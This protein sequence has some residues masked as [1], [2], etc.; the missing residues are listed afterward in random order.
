MQCEINNQGFFIP[1]SLLTTELISKI[2]ADL[3]VSPYSEFNEYNVKTFKVYKV[4][5]DSGIVIP[6][7]YA[8]E[9]L[10]LKY[11]IN[12]SKVKNEFTDNYNTNNI[13]LRPGTQQECF[14]IALGELNKPFGGGILNLTTG[15]GKSV[16]SLK[17]IC[18]SK[19]KALII[20]N[21]I[22]LMNQWKTEIKKFIPDATIGTIQGKNFD[23]EDKDIVIGM[24]QTITIKNEVT[25][26]NFFFCNLVILDEIHNFSSEVFS[27]IIFKIRPKF[28]FGLTATLQRKDKLEKLLHWYVGPVLYSNISNEKKDETEIHIY[29]YKGPSSISVTLRDNK[30]PAC[31]TM[32]TN[33]AEDTERSQ[34]IISILQDLTINKERNV[35][36]IS[37]RISQLEYMNKHLPNSALFIGTMKSE[38]L[39]KSKESQILLATYKLA[40]EGFSLAKLNCLLF[41]TSRT[42]INQAIGRI[43]RKKHEIT[44]IIVDIYDDFSFFKSQYYK[45]RKTYK[46]LISNCIFKNFTS[47]GKKAAV[48]IDLP[49]N[50]TLDFED[51]SD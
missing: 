26:H 1:K 47:K 2:K 27:K 16:L 10:D 41:A 40:S 20:V 32:L 14:N 44:P 8:L 43:Y 25:F 30:T 21:T 17:L 34:L 33:I 15:F 29:K 45:R 46:E 42:N 49:T 9:N 28:I 18:E 23:I 5:K 50:E 35:L 4:L 31:S 36:V 13:T 3:N 22:E 38:D 24:V 12:F 6:I 48:T 37:D 11:T 7:Y 39:L 19:M 51:D